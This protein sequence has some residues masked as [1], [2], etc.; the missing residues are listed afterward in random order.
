MLE[1]CHNEGI[2]LLADEVYQENVYDK[3]TK[4]FYSFK[5][6]LRQMPTPIANTQELFSFH[7]VSKGFIGECVSATSLSLP[8]LIS[9]TRCGRR[10]GYMEC[11]NIDPEIK[12][13]LYKLASISLC[14]NL[15]GQITV[16]LMV[17]PPRK[18]EPSF[19]T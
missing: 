15:D 12:A 8:S 1:F 2:V 18:G 4:P 14:P 5:K 7:S 19:D 9:S 16:D 3:K 11:T 6:V 10:G 17:R 13:Q